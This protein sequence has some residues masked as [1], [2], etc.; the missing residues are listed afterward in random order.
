MPGKKWMICLFAVFH[1]GM[2]GISQEGGVQTDQAEEI[3]G[4]DEE[5][6]VPLDTYEEIQD[7][8]LHPVNLNA[9]TPDELMACG[10]FTSFQVHMILE[11]RERYGKM[12]TIY[13]LA[14]LTGFTASSLKEISPF[15]TLED[16]PRTTRRNAPGCQVILFAGKTFPDAIGYGITAPVP[17]QSAYQGSPIKTSLKVRAV[18]GKNISLGLAYEKDP[19]ETAFSGIRP[20]FLSGYINITGHRVM[21]QVILGTYRLHLGLGLVQGSGLIHSTEAFLSRPVSLSSLKPYAGM[22]ETGPHRGAAI[23]LGLGPVKILAWSS[24]NSM[25][26][27]VANLRESGPGMDWASCRRETGLHRTSAELSGRNLAYLASSGVQ[28]MAGTS[29]LMVGCHYSCEVSGPTQK[30]KDSLDLEA[31]TVFYHSL[32]IL[33]RWRFNKLE[34]FGEYAAGSF[35][36]SAVIAGLRYQVSDFLSGCLLLHDYG[37]DHRETFS[38][39][40]ASG[41]HISN[42]KGLSLQIHAEP[43]R[44]MVADLS[45]GMYWYP[46]PRYLVPVPSSGYRYSLKI[47]NAGSGQLQWMIRFT[48][49][50]SQQTPANVSIGVRPLEETRLSRLEG[51]LIYQPLESFQW[52]TRLIGSL[53]DGSNLHQGYAGVQQARFSVSEKLK[54]TLQF[55]VFNIP[56]WE[57]RIYLYEPGLY[58]Q[59]DFPVCYGE[60]QKITLVI[61]YRPFIWIILEAK[62]S[63]LT[64]HD[65][66]QFGSGNDLVE[67]YRKYEAGFQ[68]RLDF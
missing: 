24:L 56:Q 26:L 50:T 21:E 54:S 2:P 19:G 6:R 38:S 51:R 43:F 1:L 34:T 28:A 35:P 57:N 22:D 60:G 33:W 53:N 39:A 46:A 37:S 64:Y 68:L 12:Y 31:G 47:Q 65:R 27:S 13:E 45:V 48:R 20:E 29:N 52:Q 58:H 67:G 3:L 62:A 63:V 7:L 36:S 59:F 23:Q 14:A 11:Y 5:A 40:Y 25:D 15:I 61:K 17:V 55:V 9:V 18:A 44:T 41:S 30:G 4:R 32:G 66:E 49:R 10:L 16:R 42:E 8:S